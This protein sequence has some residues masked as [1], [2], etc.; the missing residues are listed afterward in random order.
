MP[1]RIGK[2]SFFCQNCGHAKCGHGTPFKFK[3]D[4]SPGSHEYICK[5]KIVKGC[6]NT[7]WDNM[8]AAGYMTD[9]EECR[10]TVEFNEE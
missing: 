3:R 1:S 5:K 6:H 4:I 2:G 9:W 7:V 10:C 8:N